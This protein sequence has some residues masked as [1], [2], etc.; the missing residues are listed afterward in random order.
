MSNLWNFFFLFTP[1]IKLILISRYSVAYVLPHAACFQLFCCL[2][3]MFLLATL[4]TT[5][6]AL[7]SFIFCI[8]NNFL[9]VL[10]C[11]AIHC[12]LL[13]YLSSCLFAFAL[14]SPSLDLC[15]LWLHSNT[16]AC[17]CSPLWHHFHDIFC[18]SSWQHQ[19]F[20]T[21]NIFVVGYLWLV[22]HGIF[23][24]LLSLL[25]W[26]GRH[27]CHWLN[28]PLLLVI[29]PVSTVFCAMVVLPVTYILT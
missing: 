13:L 21:G 4:T 2:W 19:R 5:F 1:A 12:T 22:S 9:V 23:L 8:S 15:F 6:M 17:N 16:L 18:V 7:Y 20:L 26:L 29:Y 25:I 27:R 10:H 28:D 24:V 11:L 14:L 3:T